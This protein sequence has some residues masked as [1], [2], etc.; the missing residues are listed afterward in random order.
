MHAVHRDIR[1]LRDVEDD[2]ELSTPHFFEPIVGVLPQL[3]LVTGR[4]GRKPVKLAAESSTWC[5]LYIDGVLRDCVHLFRM[6]AKQKESISCSSQCIHER[7][8]S[9]FSCWAVPFRSCVG[10]CASIAQMGCTTWCLSTT[11]WRRYRNEQAWHLSM[12]SAPLSVSAA[13]IS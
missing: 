8:G 4:V 10:Q 5:A 1:A 3:L 2:F 11:L 9:V 12:Y 7:N 6:P 13:T